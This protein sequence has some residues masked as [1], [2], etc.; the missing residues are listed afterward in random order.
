MASEAVLRLPHKLRVMRMY[1]T[2][3]KEIVNWS[4]GRHEF[5]PR[6]NALRMEFEA[7]K[8]LSDREQI[9]KLVLHG[10]DLLA[11]FRHWE[12]TIRSEF[13]GGTVYGVWPQH[14]KD[15][16]FVPNPAYI[17]EFKQGDTVLLY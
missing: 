6:A 14:C 16:K 5:Y 11:R 3:L 10:E 2:G 17:D 1:R 4:Y 15:V 12:P 9:R 13:V 7:N 8:E